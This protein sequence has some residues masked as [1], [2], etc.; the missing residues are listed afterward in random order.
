MEKEGTPHHIIKLIGGFSD[1]SFMPIYQD[2]ICHVTCVINYDT[3]MAHYY[4]LASEE[5]IEGE[6]K[7][8][9]IWY[10]FWTSQEFTEDH[11]QY[12]EDYSDDYKKLK[13]DLEKQ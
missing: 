8:Q 9:K 2:K 10:Q 5:V 6:I 7:Y 12:L 11:D 1:G 3:K 13:K 4:H